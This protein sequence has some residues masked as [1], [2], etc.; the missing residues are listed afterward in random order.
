MNSLRG[1]GQNSSRWAKPSKAQLEGI[2]V[3][4]YLWAAGGSNGRDKEDVSSWGKSTGSAGTMPQALIIAARNN[5]T[6]SQMV[7]PSKR[8]IWSRTEM[9]SADS[10][11]IVTFVGSL[12][13]ASILSTTYCR[14]SLW[15]KQ[16]KICR[17]ICQSLS[18]WQESKSFVWGRVPTILYCPIVSDNI[19]KGENLPRYL[20]IFLETASGTYPTSISRSKGC[21][22]LGCHLNA[23]P[24]ICHPL[25]SKPPLTVLCRQ[26]HNVNHIAT[27]IAE[28][29]HLKRFNKPEDRRGR[30]K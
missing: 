7:F 23:E 5:G 2:P 30:C 12:P 13:N 9:D 21:R 4:H 6:L 3:Y 27:H 26:V 29:Y 24:R 10:P 25:V 18:A 17:I 1:Q 19:K 22:T 8:V 15:P 20:H 16:T 14:P 11:Q 28:V